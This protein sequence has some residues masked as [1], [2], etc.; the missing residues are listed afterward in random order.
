[1]VEWLWA[2]QPSKRLNFVAVAMA[3]IFGGL[4]TVAIYANCRVASPGERCIW[5][6]GR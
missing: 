5:H 3:G 6:I 4:Y 2:A 1:M